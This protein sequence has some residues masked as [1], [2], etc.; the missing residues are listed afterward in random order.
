MKTNH[1]IIISSIVAITAA[2]IYVKRKQS[3]I[4]GG[5]Q[6]AINRAQQGVKNFIINYE[7]AKK[8]N[9]TGTEK[10]WNSLNEKAKE[11]FSEFIK[12]SNAGYDGTFDGWQSNSDTDKKLFWSRHMFL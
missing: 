5:L 8:Y 6:I 11:D 4:S 1:I 2:I 10:Q 3:P 7:T 12:A 9:Y